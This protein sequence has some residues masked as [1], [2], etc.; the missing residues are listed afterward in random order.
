MEFGVVCL[1]LSDA[2]GRV[3][4]VQEDKYLY[5]VLSYTLITNI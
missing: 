3:L 5:H 1:F 2:F 4:E